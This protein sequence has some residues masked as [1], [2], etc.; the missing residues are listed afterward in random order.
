MSTE[1]KTNKVI[2][3]GLV[4]IFIAASIIGFFVSKYYG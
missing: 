3:I 2:Y 1:P 4:L